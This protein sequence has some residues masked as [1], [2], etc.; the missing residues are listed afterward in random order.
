MDSLLQAKRER[1]K[2]IRVVHVPNLFVLLT[3]SVVSVARRKLKDVPSPP[4]ELQRVLAKK[5]RGEE[6]FEGDESRGCGMQDAKDPKFKYTVHR[7]DAQCV[8]WNRHPTPSDFDPQQQQQ[9]QE[10]RRLLLCDSFV[11]AK[12]RYNPFAHTFIRFIPV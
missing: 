3:L 8:S 6:G 7:S 5:R 11:P 10:K 9:Q 2:T 1:E 4:S 12:S